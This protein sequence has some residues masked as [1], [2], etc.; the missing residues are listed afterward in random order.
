MRQNVQAEEA[1]EEAAEIDQPV[2]NLCNIDGD[3]V[4]NQNTKNEW[5]SAYVFK[6]GVKIKDRRKLPMIGTRIV[7]GFQITKSYRS[8]FDTGARFGYMDSVLFQSLN[9]RFGLV[10]QYIG[11]QNQLIVRYF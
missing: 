10:L 2:E 6:R 1:E 11:Q 4:S 8:L 7:S 5:D 9:K 3:E